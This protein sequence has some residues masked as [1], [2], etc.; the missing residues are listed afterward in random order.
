MF[1]ALSHCLTSGFQSTKQDDKGNSDS[2]LLCLL[3][4]Q[5]LQSFSRIIFSSSLLWSSSHLR[6]DGWHCHKTSRPA[7]LVG[8]RVS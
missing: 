4:L 8:T 3:L 5:L 1:G 6:P 7:K 2:L